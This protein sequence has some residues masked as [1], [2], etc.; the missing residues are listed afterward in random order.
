MNFFDFFKTNK[1]TDSINQIHTYLNENFPE[2]GDE[3]KVIL[4]CFAGLLARVAYS[5]LKISQSEKN[6]MKKIL[7][8]VAHLKEDE[9]RHISEYALHKMKELSG[10]DTRSYCKPLVD[11]LSADERYKI[12]KALFAIAAADGEVDNIETNEISYI[13]NALVLEKKYFLSAQADVREYL[14]TFQL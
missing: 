8:E 14:K 13:A 4:S 2:L 5:D 12:L 10:M 1:K 6:E 7:C 3:R 11:I 9:A